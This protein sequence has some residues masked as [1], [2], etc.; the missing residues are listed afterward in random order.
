MGQRCQKMI[1]DFMGPE[2][3][4]GTAFGG[5]FANFFRKDTVDRVFDKK[6]GLKPLEQNVKRRN[7]LCIQLSVIV[8]RMLLGAVNAAALFVLIL[9]GN[10]NT[11]LL[12][13]KVEAG[14]ESEITQSQIESI[15]DGNHNFL[16]QFDVLLLDPHNDCSLED[17][18]S[19]TQSKD[20]LN[21]YLIQKE[22]D[23]VDPKL[24]GVSFALMSWTSKVWFQQVSFA[25]ALGALALASP[26]ISMLG[27][28]VSVYI[29]EKHGGVKGFM[30]GMLLRLLR[31]LVI[32]AGV[33]SMFYAPVPGT[34]GLYY[35]QTILSLAP[36]GL[37]VVG[38][39][40]ALI[41]W[42]LAGDARES[43][44]RCSNW[45]E[46]R[47]PEMP[48]LADE[49]WP[50]VKRILRVV[51][52]GGL[53]FALPGTMVSVAFMIY[54]TIIA[55]RF[56]IPTFSFP[57][58]NFHFSHLLFFDGTFCQLVDLATSG[59]V[60]VFS[61]VMDHFVGT[62][63]P[64]INAGRFEWSDTSGTTNVM[65]PIAMA[66]V[67]GALDSIELTVTKA[68]ESEPSRQTTGSANAR[69]QNSAQE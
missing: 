31:Y 3:T 22:Q 10:F 16:Y 48:R 32:T 7:L 35:Y 24:A 30:L 69:E 21:Y 11:R 64:E 8:L 55:G 46:R 9:I 50:K 36:Q 45:W 54:Q 12:I 4:R 41:M 56:A 60:F 63:T 28:E 5:F 33:E 17:F 58:I 29:Q 19:P 18:T 37:F 68:A 14:P 42:L 27:D 65:N 52:K 6:F 51:F 40:V 38:G 57:E 53:L 43:E 39:V 49:S 62:L 34:S 47:T 2:P 61:T 1:D 26:F 25:I 20:G 23:C 66:N 67:D 59:F 13:G 44:S 15:K